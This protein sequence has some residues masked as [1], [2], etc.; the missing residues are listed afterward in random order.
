MEKCKPR[1]SNQKLVSKILCCVA[2]IYNSHFFQNSRFT[3]SKLFD[4]RSSYKHCNFS[5]GCLPVK[6]AS[7]TVT[8]SMHNENSKANVIKKGSNKHNNNF[9]RA[10]QI[11]VRFF[12]PKCTTTSNQFLIRRFNYGKRERKTFF[13]FLSEYNSIPGEFSKVRIMV[14]KFKRK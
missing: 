12:C 6:M 1:Y 13:L 4:I 3:D 9:A 2:F 10:S 5:R 11:L 8:R 14:I 7:K